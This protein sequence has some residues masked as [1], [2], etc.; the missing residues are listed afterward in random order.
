MKHRNTLFIQVVTVLA[1][2]VELHV[3]VEIDRLQDVAEAVSQTIMTSGD[4]R[5]I[6]PVSL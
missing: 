3:R 1:D 5:R 2:G 6:S 4:A